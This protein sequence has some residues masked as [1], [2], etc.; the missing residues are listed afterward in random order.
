MI[1]FVGT[2]E[3]LT[4]GNFNQAKIFPLREKPDAAN[5]PSHFCSGG[6]MADTYV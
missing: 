3:N 4:G 1:S 5:Y 2:A 6:E